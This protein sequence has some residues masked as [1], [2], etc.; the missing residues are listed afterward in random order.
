VQQ[1]LVI[2]GVAAA[3]WWVYTAASVAVALP[4][5]AACWFL[6]EKRAMRLREWKPAGLVPRWNGSPAWLSRLLVTALF[7]AYFSIWIVHIAIEN[8]SSG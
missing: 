6:V 4:L 1:F 5:A 3:G 2:A 7:L 8:G